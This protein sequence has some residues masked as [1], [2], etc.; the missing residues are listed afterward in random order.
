MGRT[1]RKLVQ[2]KDT[3]LGLSKYKKKNNAKIRFYFFVISEEREKD[4]WRTFC[5]VARDVL[6]GNCFRSRSPLDK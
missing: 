2:G 3:N 6:N 5:P 4:K 1:E